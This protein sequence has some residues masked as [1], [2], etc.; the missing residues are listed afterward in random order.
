M[1]KYEHVGKSWQMQKEDTETLE[2]K[3]EQDVKDTQSLFWHWQG[4]NVCV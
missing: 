2:R 4:V 1:S 3:N